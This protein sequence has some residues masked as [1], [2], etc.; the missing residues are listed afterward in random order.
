MVISPA[1]FTTCLYCFFALAFPFQYI[2]AASE[3]ALNVISLPKHTV[4]SLGVTSNVGYFIFVILN[5]PSLLHWVFLS[6]PV[7]YMMV[8][9]SM[10]TILST[11]VELLSFHR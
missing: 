8:S 10:V 4:M 7:M 11:S 9:L 2:I 3:V 5:E 6:I 1:S